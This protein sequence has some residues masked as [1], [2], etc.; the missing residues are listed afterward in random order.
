[1]NPRFVLQTTRPRF[2]E[3][4]HVPTCVRLTAQRKDKASHSLSGV[5]LVQLVN[6]R[7]TQE[8]TITVSHIPPSELSSYT[9][10]VSARHMMTEKLVEWVPGLITLAVPVFNTSDRLKSYIE[11]ALINGF[12][13]LP[14]Q[15]IVGNGIALLQ[16]IAISSRSI[17]SEHHKRWR[18]GSVD[19]RRTLRFSS[20][21]FNFTNPFMFAD[22]HTTGSVGMR[23]DGDC[24]S[25]SRYMENMSGAVVYQEENCVGLLLGNLRKLNGDGDLIVVGSIE[26]LVAHFAFLRQSLKQSRLLA[27]TSTPHQNGVFPIELTKNGSRFAWGSCV[28]LNDKTLVT[29]LHVVRPYMEGSAGCR[30]LLQNGELELSDVDHSFAPH[31]ELDLAFIE[32]GKSPML[33]PVRTT[34][35]LEVGDE[36]CTVG[37][38]LVLNGQFPQPLRSTGTI[39]CVVD[40]VAFDKT[41]PCV[42]VVSSLC[43]NGSS[44]GALLNKEG[45][46]I[47]LIC[48]NAQV[49]VP[50][51]GGEV[52]TEK[53]TQFCLCIPMELVFECYQHRNK[54]M[55]KVVGRAWRL[56]SFHE[57]NFKT[58]GSKL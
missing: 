53:N 14:A 40:L 43:W 9:I 54:A 26:R 24:L 15:T 42:A 31:Q 49:F 33:K 35:Q 25:D 27:V 8:V 46:V 52:K 41:I 51:V 13:L 2:M 32:L 37:Y 57:D 38:G 47:G 23:I 11:Y 6:G 7:V 55:N 4:V 50:S 34:K 58:L 16:F 44:G 19:A 36:V 48:S 1:M 29:N 30:I 39:S 20:F 17:Y 45:S 3:W 56:E 28:L 21:P 12:N 22:F 10:H 18:L 5:N